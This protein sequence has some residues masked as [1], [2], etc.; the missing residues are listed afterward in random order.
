[1]DNGYWVEK[2]EK[3][4]EEKGKEEKGKEVLERKLSVEEAI[5][6]LK[7]AIHDWVCV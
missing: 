6:R 4:A 7:T 5:D 2:K 3:L 1:M